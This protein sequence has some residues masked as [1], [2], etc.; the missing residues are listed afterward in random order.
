MTATLE[1]A[2]EPNSVARLSVPLT[3]EAGAAGRYVGKA[4]L[5][6]GALPA[7]DYIVR[8]I[9]ALDDHPPTRVIRTLR[10]AIPG[11]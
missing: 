1:L 4:A 6:I 3:I 10:K 5:P 9:V 8:A 2:D 7:G 11:K